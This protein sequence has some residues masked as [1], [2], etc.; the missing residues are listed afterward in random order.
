MTRRQL[1]IRVEVTVGDVLVLL[2]QLSPLLGSLTLFGHCIKHSQL[3]YYIGDGD[4]MQ[5]VPEALGAESLSAPRLQA[6]AATIVEYGRKQSQSRHV[7][8]LAR[9]RL[10]VV[11]FFFVPPIWLTVSLLVE[12]VT[13]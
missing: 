4:L 13:H 2:L 11:D 10:D 9:A 7:E 8:A 12:Q 3:A 5:Q 1:L 6:V